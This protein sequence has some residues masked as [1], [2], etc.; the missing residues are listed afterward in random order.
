MVLIMLVSIGTAFNAVAANAAL[1]ES[2]SN[3]ALADS[4]AAGVDGASITGKVDVTFTF[5]GDGVAV[6]YKDGSE[7]ERV[8][9]GADGTYV[10]D[11]LPAGLYNL[12]ISIPGWTEYNV[13]DI[14]VAENEQVEI[15]ESTVIA[16]DV[17]NSGEINLG[18][19]ALVLTNMGKASNDEI[20]GCDINHDGLIDI[21]DVTNIVTENNFLEKAYSS[22]YINNGYSE[23]Y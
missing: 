16:G 5:N 9:I 11:E 13:Y 10:F 22:Y 18:D 1:A 2:Y 17:D 12:L 15:L 20:K 23:T 8:D 14:S 19:I 7:F 6:L 4:T 3:T 21:A